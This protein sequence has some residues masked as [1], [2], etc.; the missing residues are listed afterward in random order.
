MSVPNEN[1]DERTRGAEA[2]RLKRAMTAVRTRLRELS[3]PEVLKLAAGWRVV[4]ISNHNR[5]GRK[6][7]PIGILTAHCD[8]RIYM[9]DLVRYPFDG[10]MLPVLEDELRKAS[11]GRLLII[12]H[13]MG[14]HHN[15]SARITARPRSVG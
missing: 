8:R 12:V 14:S 2:C 15:F 1:G 5:W 9:Q 4:L 13:L 7:G 11:G 10:D 3:K 6:D